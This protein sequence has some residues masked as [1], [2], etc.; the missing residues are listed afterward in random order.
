MVLQPMLLILVQGVVRWVGESGAE[1]VAFNGGERV[2]T[3]QESRALIDGRSSTA[4]NRVNTG[5]VINNTPVNVTVEIGT[6]NNNDDLDFTIDKFSNM[7]GEVIDDILY[8]DPQG[9][10]VGQNRLSVMLIIQQKKNLL[11]VDHS[12]QHNQMGLK[13]LNLNFLLL[14]KLILLLLK[15]L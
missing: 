13:L 4:T 7:L 10:S 1:L 9:I 2:F 5:G 11:M 6:I 15:T 12:Q 3:N 8:N 14:K